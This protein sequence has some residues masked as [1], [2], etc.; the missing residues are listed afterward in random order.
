MTTDDIPTR[1]AEYANRLLTNRPPI[2]RKEV[3]KMLKQVAAC[4]RKLYRHKERH[5]KKE[6]IPNLFETAPVYLPKIYIPK[7]GA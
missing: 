2:G 5:K 1:V 7:N 4:E 6:P 3:R